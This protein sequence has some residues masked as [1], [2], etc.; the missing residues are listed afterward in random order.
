M[1]PNNSLGGLACDAQNL[2]LNVYH[3]LLCTICHKKA[4]SQENG[5]QALD[6]FHSLEYDMYMYTIDKGDIVCFRGH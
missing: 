6:P 3:V 1:F 5:I 4:N 2:Y